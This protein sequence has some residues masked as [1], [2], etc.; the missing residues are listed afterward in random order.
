[1]NIFIFSLNGTKISLVIKSAEWSVLN[2]YTLII[3]TNNPI[4]YSSKTKNMPFTR[5]MLSSIDLSDS[6]TGI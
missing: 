2:N 1:M 5:R 4:D 6:K 3:Y